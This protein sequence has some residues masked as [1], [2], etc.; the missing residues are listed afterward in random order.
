MADWKWS[1]KLSEEI[2]FMKYDLHKEGDVHTIFN[3][4]AAEVASCEKISNKKEIQNEFLN[5]ME[6]GKFIPAGRI[7]ANSRPDS[8]MKNYNNC[9]TIEIEDSM[10][11]IYNSLKE[12]AQISK[13]GGGVGFNVSKLRPKDA[14]ISKGGESSGPISFLEVFDAS[15][16][17][18]HTGGG[19]RSAHIAVMNVDHPDIEEFITVKQGDHNKKLTQFNISVGITD[20]FIKAVKEEADW[21]LTFEGK[22]YKT[23][24]AV[25]L[26]KLMTKNAYDHNEPGIFNLDHVNNES[27]SHY[28]YYIQQVNPCLTGDT[29][30][31]VADGRDTITIKQLAEEGKDVPVYAKDDNGN[32]VIKTM[33]NPRITGY[34]EDIY[35]VKLDDGSVVKCTGNHSFRM[36]D[37]TYKEALEL[38][39]GDSLAI[40]SKWK[41]TFEEIFPK[42]NSKSQEYWMTSNGHKNIFEHRLIY[43]QLNNTKIPKG[44]VIHHKN[45]I[46]LDNSIDNLVMM[47]KKEHDAY[48]D[49][50]GDKNPMRRFPEKNWMNDPKAQ[51]AMR[52]KHHIGAKRSEETKRKI[53]EKTQERCQDEKYTEKLSTS[54]KQSW[55][56]KKDSYM[57]GVNKR[58]QKHLEDYQQQTDL[59]CFIEDNTVMVEKVCEHCGS[60]FT[61]N[62]GKRE[63]AYCSHKCSMVEHNKKLAKMS[64][65]K[66][67][68]N[69]RE[70]QTKIFNI[71]SKTVNE[72]GEIPTGKTFKSLLNNNGINDFRTAGLKESYKTYLD[73]VFS[74]FD[75]ASVSVQAINKNTENC[76]TKLAEELIDNGM[77][78]NHK[79]VSVT[80]IG[81]D[82]VYNGTVD[83]VHNFDIIFNETTTKSGRAK[84]LSCNNLQCGEQALPVYG[85]CDL[86]ALNLSM[87]VIDP[88]TPEARFDWEALF[89]AEQVGVRFLDNVLS[90]TDYPLDKIRDRSIS[91]RRIGLGFTGYADML[92]KLRITYG[93]AESKEFTDKL[94]RLF[95]D[96]AYRASIELAKEKGRFPYCDNEKL[97]KSA[98]IKRLPKDLRNDIAEYGLRNVAML[99]VAPTGTTSLSL[100]QNCSS[101]IEPIFSLSYTRN[102]RTGNGDDTASEVVYD[103]AWLT[104]LEQENRAAD[105]AKDLL[106]NSELKAPPYFVTTVDIDPKD[107]IDIQSIW[108]KYI[109]ASISK[110]LNLKHNT[111]YEEYSELFMY[112]YDQGLKGFTSFNPDGN[113][114]GI[115]E[116]NQPKETKIEN[117]EYEYVERHMAPERPDELECDIHEITVQGKKTIVLVGKLHGSLYEIFVDDNDDGAIDVNNHKTG[118]IKKIGHGRYSLIIKNGVDKVVVQNLAKDFDATWGVLARMTSM[119]LRHGTPLQFI[120]DQ[121]NKS[122]H[123]MGFERAVSRVLKKYI[124]DGEVVQTG[125]VCPECDGTLEYRE[126]CMVCPQCAWSKCS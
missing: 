58:T 93:S 126:G 23:I 112:A 55:I 67:L 74:K 108:Q 82:V 95:R 100:G 113:L 63:Q 81:K 118:F 27:N 109:D 50:S 7:L 71:F 30:V 28:L 89:E 123:F 99:T 52:E 76:R 17:T 11:G 22:V 18:I 91:E 96:S 24:K 9:F 44:S 46:G 49:I 4:I 5:I 53:G 87:F 64:R 70:L 47:T 43:E 65:N 59:K 10:D 84:L 72:S 41:T 80:K 101:G 61:V 69:Y 111:S 25:D 73:S 122:K 14:S 1:Q 62:F 38:N 13:M 98:F 106:T 121:L 88:F 39:E 8:K 75:V 6:E 34:D 83:D 56:D 77:V 37:G 120:V 26:Y 97:V 42:S 35:E 110:T 33:R 16:K 86:G 79:V 92:T 32:S 54:V 57:E 104:W 48:H 78:Y 107:T 2:F 94:G 124:K 116:Y 45:F 117:E 90:V 66:A 15:A 40:S 3:N 102:Y 103:D 105:T 12:D 114:K 85:V 29:L 36:K 51:Q 60:N 31:A 20:A 119:S 21:D 125:D 115:L 68:N 19:R